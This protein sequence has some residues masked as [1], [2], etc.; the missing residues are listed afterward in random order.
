VVT[1]AAS[2]RA[3]ELAGYSNRGTDVALAAPGGD[4]EQGVLSTVDTGRTVAEGDGYAAYAG[5]SMAAP[6]VAAAAALL[7]SRRADLTPAEL[8]GLLTRTARPTAW[9]QE[10]RCGAGVLD[11]DLALRAATGRPGDTTRLILQAGVR[12]GEPAIDTPGVHLAGTLGRLGTGLTD[13]DPGALALH[14]ADPTGP[15]RTVLTVP[16]GTE[17][18]YKYTLGDWEH[19][20]QDYTDSDAGCFDID[21]RRLTT[22]D[23]GTVQVVRDLTG[24]FR[25]VW[26]CDR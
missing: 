17:L 6:H 16:A 8:T 14:R 9:P 11:V 5:T 1:V 4:R 15:Y 19:V 18:E 26:P 12:P 22:G 20:E 23:P 24:G 21:N 13:W 7:L 10:C 25:G 2:T 3:G